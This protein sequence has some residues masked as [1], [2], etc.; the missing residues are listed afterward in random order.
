MSMDLSAPLQK[1][2][3]EQLMSAPELAFL[4]GRIFDDAPQR[5]AEGVEVFVTLGDERVRPWS[6]ATERGAEHEAEIR[7]HAPLRGF[8]KVKE[9]AA[10]ICSVIEGAP[11]LM[12]RGT[13]VNHRFTRARTQREEGGAGRR[14]DLTFRFAIEDTEI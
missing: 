12:S 7:V 9:A 10:A 2:L 3:Y 5:S 6:T 13:V 14:I 11:P 4:E 8:L 1:A